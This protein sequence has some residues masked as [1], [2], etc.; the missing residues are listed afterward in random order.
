MI[1]DPHT[2]GASNVD[3]AVVIVVLTAK[4]F[5]GADDRVVSINC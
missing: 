3:D 4:R 5:L 1:G 2:G